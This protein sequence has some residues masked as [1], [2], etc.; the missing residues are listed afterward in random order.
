M[1]SIL[2][3]KKIVRDSREKAA[4]RSIQKIDIGQL[5]FFDLDQATE[6]IFKIPGNTVEF[7]RDLRYNK[8]RAF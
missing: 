5:S 1:R 3:D 7:V 8:H 4:V 6:G 2:L